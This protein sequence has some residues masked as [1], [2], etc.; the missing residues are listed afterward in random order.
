VSGEAW[1]VPPPL[2]GNLTQRGLNLTRRPTSSLLGP[3]STLLRPTG[4]PWRV[5]LGLVG[6][7]TRPDLAV[8]ELER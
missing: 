4:A 5:L 1:A 2:P 7:L 8:P 6:N 3:I